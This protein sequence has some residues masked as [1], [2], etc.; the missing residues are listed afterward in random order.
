[1]RL[2][3]VLAAATSFA[4][5]L[6]QPSAAQEGRQFKDAWFWGA[7][8]GALVYSTNYTTD[9]AVA[10]LAGIDW[11]ITRTHGGLYVTVDQAFF[12]STGA[13]KEIGTTGLQDRVVTLNNL[14]RISAAA[15][16]FPM[17]SPTLHPYV[18]LGMGMNRIGSVGSTSPF[19]NNAQ[20]NAATDSVQSKRV[21]FAPFLIAGVQKRLPAFSVFAQGTGTFLHNEFF[22]HNPRPKVGIQYTI[23]GGIRYNI[24]SSI[25]RAR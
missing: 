19:A 3:R 12:S 21:S 22:L 23:E 11:M 16:G 8:G 10:P 20:L 13:F 9:N 1:M 14:Q 24:G 4:A 15:V 25:D 7:K 18:G 17:Q 5:L 2:L 6:A